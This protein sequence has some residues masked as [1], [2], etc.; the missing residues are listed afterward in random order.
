MSARVSVVVPTRN[1]SVLLREALRSIFA[2]RGPDLELEVIVA[3]N[4]STDDTEEVARGEGAIV[5]QAQGRGAGAARN[6]G[7]RAATGEFIAFLDDD[8]LWTAQHLRPHL[9][10]MRDRPELDA[11]VGQVCNSDMSGTSLSA[12][13]PVRA[14]AGD[15]FASFF[16][17]YPQIGATVLRARAREKVPWFDESLLGDQDW[18]FHLRLALYTKVAFVQVPCVVFRQREHAVDADLLWLRL[19]FSRRV[20]WRNALR[21]GR[22]MPPP[23]RLLRA[24]ARQRGVFAGNLAAAARDLAA[25]GEAA[26]ARRAALRAFAASPLHAALYFLRDPPFR[27]LLF[28]RR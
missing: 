11:V 3:D 24:F 7:L 12:P 28:G 9:A 20:F 8:D 1:R 22:R 17:W 21:G 23:L 18:D 16:E 6:A 10:L 5:V 19:S 13:W 2:L 25:G 27:A 15:L 4:G 14:P 26:G